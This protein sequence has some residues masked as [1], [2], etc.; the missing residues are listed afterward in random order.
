VT[1]ATPP[2]QDEQPPPFLGS[3]T[4]LYAVVIAFLVLQMI[5]YAAFSRAFS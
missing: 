5:L 2:P 1:P 4:R 3:W